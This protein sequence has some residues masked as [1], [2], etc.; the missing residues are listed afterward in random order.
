M[1]KAHYSTY[2]VLLLIALLYAVFCNS[3]KAQTHS[4]ETVL[5]TPEKVKQL[6]LSCDDLD[7]FDESAEKLT[8]LEALYIEDCELEQLPIEI[9]K[10]QN[11]TLL[12]VSGNHLKKLPE[13]LGRLQEIKVVNLRD[14]RFEYLPNVLL[15][16]P[17]LREID[18]AYNPQINWEVTT[19]IL[20][21]IEKLDFLYLD[22]N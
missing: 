6:H 7:A 14:N 10:L 3:L 21:R 9:A 4:L 11:L 1:F 19:S 17:H 12:N 15:K 8:P 18:L 2:H 16:M 20:S 13:E 5:R 22:G